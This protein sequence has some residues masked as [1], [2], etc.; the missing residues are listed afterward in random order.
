MK[1]YKMKINGNAYEVNLKILTSLLT[2]CRKLVKRQS[3]L[4][5]RNW[6]SFQEQ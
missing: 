4:K 5:F 1:T 3:K 6:S 2:I